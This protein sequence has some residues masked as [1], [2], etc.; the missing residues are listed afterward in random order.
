MA[1][2]PIKTPVRPAK[3]GSPFVK[4]SS[5]DKGGWQLFQL[6]LC[7]LVFVALV[8]AKVAWPAS[9]DSVKAFIADHVTDGLDVRSA[10]A[11]LRGAQTALPSPTPTIA[12]SSTPAGEETGENKSTDSTVWDDMLPTVEPSPTVAPMASGGTRQ[13]SALEFSGD[14]KDLQDDSW[15]LPFNMPKPDVVDFGVYE[16]TFPHKNP[17]KH[18]AVT[19]PFGYRTHPVDGVYKFHYGIDLGEDEG[20]PIYAFSDGEVYEVGRNDIYGKFLRIRHANG[21]TSFYGHCSKILAEEGD[22]VKLGDKVALVGQ[23]GNVTGPHLH[24]EV[25]HKGLILDPT[26]YLT[27]EGRTV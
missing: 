15:P 3:H 5:G 14:E 9:V 8:V 13:I 24:F 22:T 19:S 7:L 20:T 23:T 1:R 17:L 10:F 2:K 26:K 11:S 25:R 4:A 27:L 18:M 16:M 12:P 6:L 21:F